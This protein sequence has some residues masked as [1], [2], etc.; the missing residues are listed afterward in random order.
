VA[1]LFALRSARGDFVMVAWPF[2]R[3]GYSL[4]SSAARRRLGRNC[5]Q[6]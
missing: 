2:D 3:I 5:A 4:G 6:R 1:S